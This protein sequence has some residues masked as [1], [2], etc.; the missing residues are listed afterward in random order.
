MTIKRVLIP[1][2]LSI[3]LACTTL[4]KSSSIKTAASQNTDDL[5]IVDCLLPGQIRK[6]GQLASYITARRAIKTSAVECEVRGGEY[7]AYDRANYLTALNTWMPKAQAGDSEAQNYVGEIY[8]KGMGIKPDYEIAHLWYKKSALQGYNKAQM[9]LGYLYEKGLGV[10]QNQQTAMEWYGKS[11]NLSTLAIPYAT[12]ISTDTDSTQLSAELKLLKTALKNSQSETKYL[13]TKLSSSNDRL[14]KSKSKLA[15]LQNDLSQVKNKI[16]TKSITQS[17]T[18]EIQ[19][20]KKLLDKKT[21]EINRQKANIENLEEKHNEEINTLNGTLTSTQKRAEQIITEL[22]KEKNKS[23]SSQIALLEAEAKLAET[24]K[25]LLKINNASEQGRIDLSKIKKDASKDNQS[26]HSAEQKLDD[27]Q[28][29]IAAYKQEQLKNQQT[30]ANLTDKNQHIKSIEQDIKKQMS[31]QNMSKTKIAELNKQLLLQQKL[32][33]QTQQN[34]EL[35][36]SQLNKSQQEIT[37]LVSLSQ[38]QLKKVEHEKALLTSQVESDI[39]LKQQYLQDISN[40]TD[41]LDTLKKK[42][43]AE[44]MQHE[45]NIKKLQQNVEYEQPVVKPKIEIIDPP[46]VLTRGVPTVTLRSIVREREIIGK[47]ESAN[48]LLSLSINDKKNTPNSQGLFKSNIKILNK[49]T[50]VTIVAVDNKGKKSSLNFVLSLSNIIQ[51]SKNIPESI[52]SKPDNHWKKLNFGNY[53]ALIIA[54]NDYQKVPKLETPEADG[55][56]VEKVLRTRYGFKTKLLLNATRYQILSAL[57]KL[58]GELSE[59]D[60]LLIYYAGHGEL[61]RVN[62]RGHWL[63]VDADGDNTANWISTVAITDLL[64]AMA[65]KHVL[66]VSDSCYSGAMTRSS[67]A[68]L[69]TGVSKKQRHKWLQAMLKTRSR[70][71][72]TSG[73]LKP[74]MDGGGGNHS[75]FANAFIK[76]LENNHSLLEGQA[77]YRNVSSYIVAIASD[78]G[79]DQVPEYA[80]IRH[81]GHESGE[82]FFVPN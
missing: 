67:L 50:P 7:V 74:V 5:L 76:A 38:Q 49:E 8:E 72:L 11:S 48:G 12:T 3:F 77:L 13:K 21:Q 31:L 2:F 33:N 34:L 30:I 16:Q 66:I 63:P 41:E 18:H 81:A 71:V 22:K 39:K 36:Q 46:F 24:E 20:L 14:S 51:Q 26:L 52:V 80:P 47:V 40:K 58:R 44:K 64:N 70:T 4:P 42:L 1:L 82:F 65:V 45:K 56:A 23:V 78:Y 54:N 17:N 35:T 59:E 19:Q 60:N 53:H 37:N 9:N 79:I 27:T 15:S 55:R 6:L 57:N 29:K 69:D 32:A 75:V 62:M 43:I 61:D 68:R 25:N 10:K 73:G 28:Q